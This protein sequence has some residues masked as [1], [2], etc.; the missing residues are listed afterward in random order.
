M[1]D[2]NVSM[3][4][5]WRNDSD[6]VQARTLKVLPLKSLP[7][8]PLPSPHC[9]YWCV[10]LATRSSFLCLAFLL[11]VS[12]SVLHSSWQCLTFSWQCLRF[13]L[14]ASSIPVGA[15][16]IIPAFMSW[17]YFSHGIVIRNFKKNINE[18]RHCTTVRNSDDN[19]SPLRWAHIQICILSTTAASFDQ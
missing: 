3:V 5:D 14:T 16:Y 19:A 15:C 1:N 17:Y 6:T 12:D 11:K 13:L 7:D 10:F 4:L 2:N 9:P 8:Q 18:T